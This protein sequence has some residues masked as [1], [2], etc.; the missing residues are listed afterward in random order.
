MMV[1]VAAMATQ[2]H[3]NKLLQRQ[4][5]YAHTQQ[6]CAMPDAGWAPEETQ[7]RNIRETN[8]VDSK[9]ILFIAPDNF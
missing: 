7:L 2:L 5:I 4:K 8:G 6:T 1:I 9:L 3:G